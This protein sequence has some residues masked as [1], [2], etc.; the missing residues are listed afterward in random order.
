MTEMKIK[1]D[2]TDMDHVAMKMHLGTWDEIIFLGPYVDRLKQ[3]SDDC[4]IIFHEELNTRASCVNPNE[5]DMLGLKC[6]LNEIADRN[7]KRMV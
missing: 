4:L 1:C 7:I 2:Y 6:V 3:V 5:W